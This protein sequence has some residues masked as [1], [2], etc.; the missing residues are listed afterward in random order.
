MKLS[1]KIGQMMMVGFEGTRPSKEIEA[2]IQEHCIGGVIL[3]SR[4]IESPEQCAELT[5][6]LQA[7]SPDAP[8][9]IAVD[10]E[11]GRISRLPK[12]FTQFPSARTVGRCNSVP[13]TYDYAEAMSRELLAVGINMNLAPVLDINTNPKNPVI[14][15]R[16]FGEKP[17][18]VSKHAMAV[19]A[20]MIDQKMIPCGKHFPGHGDTEQ[21]SH[22]SLP[23]V[24]LA[25]SRLT[26]R[27]LR[28]FQHAIENRLPCLM[29]AHICCHA[30]DDDLPAS[31]SE[32][33]VKV[34]LRETMKFD[35]VIMTDDLE[36][37]AITDS[38]SV[39]EAAVRAVSVGSDL[40]L[41]C[42]RADRQI[43]AIEALVQAVEQGR[44]P[45]KRIDQSLNRLL[46]LK[47]KFLLPKE[48]VDMLELRGSIGSERHLDLVKTIK[49]RGR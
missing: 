47:E 22:E 9:L 33:V 3:F 32:N 12:P 44:I 28:P 40:V 11:G 49:R 43:A 39:A 6:S 34:L 2:L 5:A 27:E 26:D 45:E 13:L 31:L 42:H 48:D 14:G 21:D 10:Q 35:G 24:T 46:S 41:V 25:L 7:L 36:M 23:K 29:T 8:L 30:F 19:I 1:H 37:K 16:A 15:D 18:L 17:T 38:Y 20:S 4:N